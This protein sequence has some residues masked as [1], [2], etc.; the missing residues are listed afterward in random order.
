MASIRDVAQQAGVSPMTVSR[1]LNG[2]Y[3]V[4]DSTR[5]RVL[6]AVKSLDYEPNLHG[7]GLRQAR[8]RTV[9]VAGSGFVEPILDGIHKSAGELG[10]EVVLVHSPPQRAD[11]AALSRRV[12]GGLAGG[13]LFLNMID[14]DAIRTLTALHPVVQCGSAADVPGT[15]TVTVDEERAAYELVERLMRQGRRRVAYVAMD[16]PGGPPSMTRR[17]EQGIRRALAAQGLALEPERLVRM[18]HLRDDYAPALDLARRFAAMPEDVRPDAVVYDQNILAVACVNVMREAGLAVPGSVA[19]ASMDD[20][21]IDLVIQPTLTAVGRPYKAM[22]EEAMRMLVDRIENPEAP[23]RQVV[24][25]HILE[26]RGS[27]DPA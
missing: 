3:P 24:F 18:T 21:P 15:C 12:R 6:A 7:R 19:V 16:L 1:V 11:P 22:G 13:I 10:Y 8:S 4:K 20:N 23:C 5:R 17:R 2:G 14:E 9:L 27:T 26:M 25:R